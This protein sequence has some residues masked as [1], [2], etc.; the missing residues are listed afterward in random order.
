MSESAVITGSARGLAGT[1]ARRLASEGYAVGLLDADIDSARALANELASTT[2]TYALE[3]DVRDYRSIGAAL[4]QAAERAGGIDLLV[5]AA[6]TD[7]EKPVEEI[8]EAE[9]DAVIGDILDLAVY[10]S[11]QA[12]PYLERSAD[13]RIVHLSSIYARIG[14]GA[15]AAVSAAAGA[16]NAASRSLAADL[17]DRGIRS[18]TV[19]PYTVLPAHAPEGCDDARWH[20]LQEST[21]LSGEIQT[22]EELAEVV[23]YVASPDGRILNA[24]DLAVDGGMSIFRERPTASAYVREETA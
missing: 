12:V 7:L 2:S 6:P 16:L 20:D 24:S 1:I 11:V 15:H 8:G 10:S 13:P 17:S 4:A 18:T 14:T 3:V 9:W 22:A 23:A 21:V 19:S 5:C